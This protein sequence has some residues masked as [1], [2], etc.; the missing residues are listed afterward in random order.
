MLASRED[1]RAPFYMVVPPHTCGSRNTQT[2]QYGLR[3]M[4]THR[5][6][7]VNHPVI[8]RLECA[9]AS[10]RQRAPPTVGDTFAPSIDILG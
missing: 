7:G 5:T 1:P 8:D 2:L 10:D 4:T 9:S 3:P 6:L